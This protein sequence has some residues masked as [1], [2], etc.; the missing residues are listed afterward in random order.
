M[1][2]FSPLR[3]GAWLMRRLKL[4]GKLGWCAAQSLVAVVLAVMAAPWWLTAAA[5]ILMLYVQL[6]LWVTLS[7]DM[8]LVARSMQQTTQGDLTVHAS[9]QGH[10]E[11]AEMARSL[12]QMV[13]KLSAMVADIRS[14]AALVATPA[15]AWHMATTRWPT[16]L[17]SRQPIWRRRQPVWKSSRPPS[18]TMPTLP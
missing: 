17:S 6:V 3:P 18:K 15:R 13:Y 1:V 5:C 11:M 12:D 2:A 10:D 7:H 4:P 14:N 9:L 8:A 16:G